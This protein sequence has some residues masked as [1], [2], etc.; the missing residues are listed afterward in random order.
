MVDG[1]ILKNWPQ[2]PEIDETGGTCA[3]ISVSPFN[4]H[5]EICPSASRPHI[6]NG[7]NPDLVTSLTV[8]FQGARLE[9]T[10]KSIIAGLHCVGLFLSGKPSGAHANAASKLD[11]YFEQGYNDTTRFLHTDKKHLTPLGRMKRS[12]IL[13]FKQMLL[14]WELKTKIVVF[15]SARR[16]SMLVGALLLSSLAHDDF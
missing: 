2:L 16:C 5:F 9:V 7:W 12:F 11:M 3:T 13:G 6:P 15:S 4:G 10:G 1:G 8:P 14:S